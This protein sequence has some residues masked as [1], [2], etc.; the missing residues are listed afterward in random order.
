MSGTL[1]HSRWADGRR[2]LT[3]AVERVLDVYD[4][5]FHG[6]RADRIVDDL[7]GGRII[8]ERA[9]GELRA[10]V[11]RGRGGWLGSRRGPVVS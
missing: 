4:G 10:L 8:H 7:V 3:G 2:A 1:T 9:A 11:N 6:G 5:I